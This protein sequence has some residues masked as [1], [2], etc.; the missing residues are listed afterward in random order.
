MIEV[1]LRRRGLLNPS[2]DNALIQT[3]NVI[4]T[5]GKITI[6][7]D[8][9]KQTTLDAFSTNKCRLEIK[10]SRPS[11]VKVRKG[12]RRTTDILNS[13]D[14]DYLIIRGFSDNLMED[15]DLSATYSEWFNRKRVYV[16]FSGKVRIEKG[17]TTYIFIGF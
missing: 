2:E 1:F 8:G 16:T 3:P 15:L 7:V 6:D 5:S 10:I 12:V 11:S 13:T 9:F 4:E 14:I 17:S